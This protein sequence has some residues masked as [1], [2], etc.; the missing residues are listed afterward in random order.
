VV[1]ADN[2]A[3]WRQVTLGASANGL[4]IVT[5]GLQ[6]GERVVVNGLQRVRPGA[7]LDPQ[8]VAMDARPQGPGQQ[9]KADAAA[10]SKS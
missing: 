2:K 4:R 7:V 9:A 6:P 3:Q 8:P 10:G 5:Q 1:D